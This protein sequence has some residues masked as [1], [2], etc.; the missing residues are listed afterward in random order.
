VSS[1]RV[2]DT[3]VSDLGPVAAEG[4]S[5]YPRLKRFLDVLL[6]TSILILLAPLL[7]AIAAAIKLESPGPVFFTQERVRGWRPR[8][9]PGDPGAAWELPTFR[10]YKF[11]T[12][13][14]D[15]DPAV[16]EEHIKAFVSGQITTQREGRAS[17]KL[18]DDS[19]ITRIGRVL[20]RTSLDELPQLVNVLRGDMSL[21]GPRPLPIYEVA[22]YD[23]RFRERFQ[24][25]AGV[26]GLWQINGRSNISFE[27]MMRLDLEYVSKQ[28]LRLDLKILLLTIPAVLSGRGAG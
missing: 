9:L 18:Q 3:E 5:L 12:M 16:H 21:V 27:E 28:S 22:Y 10:F 20:R 1:A 19:R 23:G 15:A 13:F 8:K 14:V 17:F 6:S 25:P 7:A 11:R 2:A 4:R 26:T 24:A